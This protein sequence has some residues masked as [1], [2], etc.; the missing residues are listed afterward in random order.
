MEQMFKF[1]AA[2]KLHDV[3]Q[4]SV[5]ALDLI[6]SKLFQNEKKHKGNIQENCMFL[7]QER[8]FHMMNI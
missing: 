7:N 6:F 8:Y 4:E 3:T 5:K 1:I 2:C